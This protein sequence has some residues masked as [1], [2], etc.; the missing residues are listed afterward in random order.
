MMTAIW[1]NTGGDWSLLAPAPFPDEAAL[2][3]LVEQGPHI[4]PLAGAPQLIVVG[5]EVRLGAGFADLIAIEP[6]GR[7]SVIEIKLARNAEARRAVVAQALAYAAYLYRLEPEALERDILRQH[8]A[9]RGHQTLADT[10]AAHDQEG[11]FDV[12]EFREGLRDCLQR[13]HLRVVFVLDE[14]PGELSQLVGFLEAVSDGLVLDLVTV[15]AYE[16]NG[17]QILVP[18]RVEPE[19]LETPAAGEQRPTQKRGV[20]TPGP[21]EFVADAAKTDERLRPQ[22]QLLIDFALRL[23]ENGLAELTSYRGAEGR[24]MLLLPR[25][26]P[27]NVGV[28]TLWNENGAA[29]Q[30]WRS[31]FERNA[32]ETLERVEE[33]VECP[34]G[35]LN[36]EV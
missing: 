19:K 22:L 28:V 13:G 12:D 34:A 32:P 25:I 17:S 3:R 16:V 6:N 20:S 30:F 4:L 29:I 35:K 14:A 11:D 27:E 15:S 7:L 33:L 26:Q 10:V 9:E 5:R 1:H 36:T 2:H 31:V 8:L 18:Q 24:R 21:D 23:E